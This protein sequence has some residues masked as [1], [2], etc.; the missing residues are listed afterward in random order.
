MKIVYIIVTA[1]WLLVALTGSFFTGKMRGD[2][3]SIEIGENLLYDNPWT[4]RPNLS[5]INVSLLFVQ[6][7]AVCAVTTSLFLLLADNKAKTRPVPVPE[8]PP[9]KTRGIENYRTMTIKE[10]TLLVNDWDNDDPRW[11][12]L[13]NDDR[14]GVKRLVA[15]RD[16]RNK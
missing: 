13:V 12:S 1:S 6:W 3:S 14:N 8:V 5:S 16:G 9:G 10:I 7:L 15:M 11:A 4:V 2:Y